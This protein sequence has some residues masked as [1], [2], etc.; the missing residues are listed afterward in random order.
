MQGEG[1][2]TIASRPACSD[3][4]DKRNYLA[5]ARRRAYLALQQPARGVRFS[6]AVR[7]R[8]EVK[9]PGTDAR[10]LTG[11]DERLHLNQASFFTQGRP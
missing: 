2:S 3:R 5:F 9:G 4:P 7:E 8:R 1:T 6:A 10:Y 11:P